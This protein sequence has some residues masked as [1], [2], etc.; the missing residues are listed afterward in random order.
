MNCLAIDDEPL[1]LNVIK[2]YCERIDFLNLVTTCTSAMEALKYLNTQKVDLLFLDIQMPH[3]SGLEF[4]KT[5]SSPPI[6]I[7]TT[8]F[9]QHA[10]EGFDLNALDYLLKPIPFD[11][12]LQAVNKAF[13]LHNLRNKGI[14]AQDTPT[15][16]TARAK[17]EYLM[18]KV[19]YSTKKINLKDIEYIEGLKDYVKIYIEHKPILTKSTM[20]NIE[21]KLPEDEFVRVH[22]SFIVS[23][24]HI[25][26]IENNRIIIGDKYIP[27]GNQYKQKFNGIVKNHLL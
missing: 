1:A 21:S 4:I 3:I 9:P 27:V 11:R 16:T 8:A 26:A 15:N 7:F 24:S 14:S 6:L 13:D 25:K 2:E 19:E 22:K 10:L 18:I 20:K 5:L 23:L 17:P 12:F